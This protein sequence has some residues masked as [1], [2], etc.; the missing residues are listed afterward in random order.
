MLINYSSHQSRNMD[1]TRSPTPASLP[2]AHLHDNP[3]T[4]SFLARMPNDVA[5][6]FTPDQLAVVQMAFGMR[7]K[8]DHGVDFRRTLSLPWGRYYFILLGGRDW[9]RES[10]R[11]GLQLIGR[12]VVDTLAVGVAGVGIAAAAWRAA[13][14]LLAVAI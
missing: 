12:L 5:S 7:Y 10:R 14:I 9:R 1:M 11:V 2:I 13:E 3:F 6:S 8:V 4:E